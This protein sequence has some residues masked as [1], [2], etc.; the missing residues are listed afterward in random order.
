MNIHLNYKNDS[1]LENIGIGHIIEARKNNGHYF[2][3]I[4]EG[5]DNGYHIIDME[6]NKVLAYRS[7]FNNAKQYIIDNFIIEKTVNH[8]NV[9]L[10]LE[11]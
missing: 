6:H 7:S 11:E 8:K 10:E 4:F 5:R 1:K 3:T 9:F 2:L